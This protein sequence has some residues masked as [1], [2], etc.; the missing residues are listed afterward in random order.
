MTQENRSLGFQTKS[1]T[2]RPTT[3]QKKARILKFLVQEEEG[4]NNPCSVN[5]GADQL[6]SNLCFRIGKNPVFL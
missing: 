3:P 4:W 1:D 5:K 6:C 2:N